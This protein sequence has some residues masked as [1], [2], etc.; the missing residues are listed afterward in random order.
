LRKEAGLVP[1]RIDWLSNETIAESPPAMQFVRPG[2]L[3]S[4]SGPAALLRIWIIIVERDR[5][6][7]IRVIGAVIIAVVEVCVRNA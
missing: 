2:P 1:L 4:F 3:G 5:V 7:Q 6:V